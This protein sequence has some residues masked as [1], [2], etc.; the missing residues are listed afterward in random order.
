MEMTHSQ[1]DGHSRSRRPRLSLSILPLLGIIPSFLLAT[2]SL[3]EPWARARFLL[4]VGISRSPGAV[5]LVVVTLAAMVASSVAIAARGRRRLMLAAGVH[6]VTG[7]VMLV[8]AWFAFHMVRSA[9][10]KLLFIPITTVRPGRGLELWVVASV[11][12]VILGGVELGIAEWR[13]RKRTRL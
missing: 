3:T 10:Y 4:V 6:V 13:E 8:V 2:Y 7:L 12:I 5:A 1:G 9:G 11:L